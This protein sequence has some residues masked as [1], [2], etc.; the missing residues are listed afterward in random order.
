MQ[1]WDIQR[2]SLEKMKRRDSFVLKIENGHILESIRSMFMKKRILVALFIMMIGVFSAR[3]FTNE[4]LVEY[5]FLNPYHLENYANQSFD[6]KYL[7]G[8]I[9]WSRFKLFLFPFVLVFTPIKIDVFQI[10]RYIIYYGLGLFLAIC[11]IWL[12][13]KGIVFFLFGIGP[14]GILYMGLLYWINNYPQQK[15]AWL[16][17]IIC[18]IL[19]LLGCFVECQYGTPLLQ[20]AV[21]FC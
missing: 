18:I 1:L 12:G 21:H 7:F 19:F 4:S 9:V 11:V 6:M 14:Q 16:W 8:R 13:L 10:E 17:V 20:W 3:L 5:G 2:I 15:H